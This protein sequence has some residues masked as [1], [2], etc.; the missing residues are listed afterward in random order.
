[1]FKIKDIK[2]G[3]VPYG[4]LCGVGGFLFTFEN[5]KEKV[6]ETDLFTS[7]EETIKNKGLEKEWINTLVP[8]FYM[9]FNDVDGLISNS[10]ENRMIFSKLMDIISVKSLN[11]QKTVALSKMRPPFLVYHGRALAYTMKETWYE[12]FQ[13]LCIEL[14]TKMTGDSDIYKSYNTLALIEQQNHNFSTF[15]FK[16]NELADLVKIDKFYL[17]KKVLSLENTRIFLIP[18]NDEVK[19]SNVFF[20]YIKK[21]G[22]RVNL[23]MIDYPCINDIALNWSDND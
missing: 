10:P 19:K 7:I 4:P 21:T 22:Y 2:F 11:M 18:E 1:M 17:D 13:V 16:I 6:N 12:N 14:D 20:D 15:M 23:N 8:K 5:E 3:E 9:I